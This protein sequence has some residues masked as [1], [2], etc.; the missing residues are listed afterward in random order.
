MRGI[1]ENGGGDGDAG[2]KE[3]DGWK[4]VRKNRFSRFRS[5]EKRKGDG[6]DGEEE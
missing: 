6:G 2:G 4:E 3:L 5:K 1:R